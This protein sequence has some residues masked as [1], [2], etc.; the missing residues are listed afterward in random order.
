MFGKRLHEDWG[1]SAIARLPATRHCKVL[2]ISDLHFPRDDGHPKYLYE[3][4]LHH[5]CDTLVLLGDTHEGYAAELKPF[6]EMN[7]RVWD[8]IAARRAQGMKV[9]DLPGNHDSYK[10]HDNIIGHKA[11]G[12]EYWNDLVVDSAL[13]PTYLFHGDALDGKMTRRYDKVAYK[14]A[15][16][17]AI[18]KRSLLGVHNS[19]ERLAD[20]LTGGS[21][22]KRGSVIVKF[23][24]AALA[25]ENDCQAVLSGHTHKPCVFSPVPDSEEILYGNTGAW[26]GGVMTAM[27]MTDDGNW[28]LVNWDKKRRGFYNLKPD[29]AA[30]A[31]EFKPFRQESLHEYRWQHAQHAL[32]A[33]EA[34]I[35]QTRKALEN[36]EKIK[37][38]VM[39][40]L[41]TAEERLGRIREDVERVNKGARIEPLPSKPS[42]LKIPAV[43]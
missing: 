20:H 3:F 33:Q 37:K 30:A 16:K 41:D 38:R 39:E 12:T 22:K 6:D 24:A 40:Y 5:T 7:L 8:L 27:L 9:I 23:A 2:V 43:A 14:I 31:H 42:V 21:D 34:L 10:R 18:G 28:E 29:G 26:V 19:L 35:E 17:I 36:V 1:H 11:F 15:K 13:G 25:R 4:L 32:F